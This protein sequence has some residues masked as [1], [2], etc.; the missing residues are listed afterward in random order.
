MAEDAK[1][2][3]AKEKVAK[4]IRL[5]RDLEDKYKKLLKDHNTLGEFVKDMFPPAFYPMLK[6]ENS[7][8]N[9]EMA[10]VQAAY[11]QRNAEARSAKAID[12]TRLDAQ[13][14]LQSRLETV[15]QQCKERE[16]EV[17]KLR[18]SEGEWQARAK[19]AEERLQQLEQDKRQHDEEKASTEANMLLMKLKR[20]TSST[21]PNT[22]AQRP[23]RS[24]EELIRKVSEQSEQILKLRAELG[25]AQFLA[26]KL[27]Q[28]ESIERC[29]GQMQTDYDF[30]AELEKSEALQR[31]LAELQSEF[32]VPFSALLNPRDKKQIATVCW[33][34]RRAR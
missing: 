22:S 21:L 26:N 15:Q 28:L 9:L 2:D 18:T 24:A 14:E 31:Q 3:I 6:F 7:A 12:Q 19:A 23:G 13:L 20:G 30:Q 33:L 25:K 5:L 29:D 32:L 4:I 8:G 27:K 11:E 16:A 34:K 10:D 1:S 17:E